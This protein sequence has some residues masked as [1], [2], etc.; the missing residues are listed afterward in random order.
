MIG[1]HSNSWAS[2]FV[3]TNAEQTMTMMKTRQTGASNLVQT[4]LCSH[5]CQPESQRHEI[6][7]GDAFLHHHINNG[8]YIY[9]HELW[10][11]INYQSKVE[12]DA[13]SPLTLL[14]ATSRDRP[15]LFTIKLLLNAG[16]WINTEVSNKCRGF[17]AH[18]LTNVRSRLNAG[19]Q[20]NAG[21]F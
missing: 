15:N 9:A 7:L 11:F 1:Y 20:I 17:E 19:S 2:C 18:V 21:V 16:S 13:Q 12:V 4:E 6:F 8:K 14:S 5:W 3:Y 10:K